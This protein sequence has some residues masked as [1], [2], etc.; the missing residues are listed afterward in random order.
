M[1]INRTNQSPTQ[2]KLIIKA[3]TDEISKAKSSVIK[4]LAPQVKVPG[5][6]AGNVPPALVEK[7]ID[8]S[9]LQSEVLET[10]ISKLYSSAVRQ[11]D[12]RPIANP[13]I[14]I[15]KFVPFTDLEFEAD[16]TVIGEIK[17]ADYKKIKHSKT[18]AKVSAKDIDEVIKSLQTRAAERKTVKREAKKG[19]EVT[20]DFKGTNSKGEAISGADAKEYPLTLG[21]DSFIPGFED[22]IIGLKA[23]EE[24]TFDITFP[25]DYAAKALQ[26]KKVKFTVKVHKVSELVEPKLDD[27]FA[28]AVGPFKSVDE[29]KEDIKKQLTFEREREAN[30]VFENE[31]LDK[32][33]DKTTIELPNQLIDEQIDR[34]E[35]E[36][37]QNLMYRGQTWEEHL[38]EEGVTAEEHR[39][40]KR[41]AA[42]KRV[43]IGIILSEVSEREE[44]QVTPEEIEVR[45]Q[46]MKGQYQDPTAQAELNKPEALRDIETRIRTEKTLAK[47][48]DYATKK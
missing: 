34:I 32:I 11:E 47:L 8:P 38:K 31:L 17:L 48:T 45:L 4:K 37:K 46:I 29:L 44:I 13:E 3:S 41:P 28:A 12:L 40:Q 16:I 23:G 25:K 14:A 30:T 2:T 5:F 35:Q 15:K 24:K 1:H 27:D 22:E 18:I 6:R 36:E 10:V 20:I 21:S 26:G 7:N 9:V 43:K 39:E 19:D 42:E 33:A